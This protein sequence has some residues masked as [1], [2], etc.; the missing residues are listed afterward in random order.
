[1]VADAGAYDDWGAP[2]QR[3]LE[4]AGFITA[5]A[6][7]VVQASAFGVFDVRAGIEH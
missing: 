7:A 1:M 6:D 5:H 2:A 4:G 3:G